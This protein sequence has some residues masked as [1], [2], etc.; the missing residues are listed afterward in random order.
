M[1]GLFLAA[2]LNAATGDDFNY[3]TM[4]TRARLIDIL[5]MLPATPDGDP[6]WVYMEQHMKHVMEVESAF[7]EE[8]DRIGG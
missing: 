7:A 5:V 3:Q 8:L 4:C 2:A 1:T 6:D